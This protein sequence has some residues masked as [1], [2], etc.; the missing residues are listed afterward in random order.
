MYLGRALH[1]FSQLCSTALQCIFGFYRCPKFHSTYKELLQELTWAPSAC[2]IF[3]IDKTGPQIALRHGSFFEVLKFVK[4]LPASGA[5]RWTWWQKTRRGTTPNL[6]VELSVWT[7]GN[8]QASYIW[9][10]VRG[11][12]ACKRC[13]VAAS[14]SLAM[15]DLLHEGLCTPMH[16][17][18]ASPAIFLRRRM[19]LDI[20]PHPVQYSK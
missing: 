12:C 9:N 2:T 1:T 4:K 10:G 8:V 5:K 16:T 7:R 17:V 6:G 13:T 3:S 20:F 11:V 19:A 18:W 14:S 15:I